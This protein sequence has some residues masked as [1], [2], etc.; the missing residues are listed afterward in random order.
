MNRMA[1]FV[2]GYTEVVFVDKLIREIAE[3]NSVLIQWRRIAGGTTCLRSNHQIQA[4]GPHAGQQ[5]F[6]VIHDCGGDEAVKTRM[7]EE[8]PLLSKAG[9]SKIVCIRD[10][11]PRVTY[12]KI[13][14]LEAGL[15]AF[16]RT[17]PIIVD[18][19]LSIMEVEAWFLAEHSH[20]ERVHSAIT[21]PAI[22]AALNFDP[23]T[24]DMQLRPTP[25]DDMVACYAIGAQVYAKAQAQLTVDALDYAY[26]YAGLV[27]KFPYLKRL[28][29]VITT[30]L[31]S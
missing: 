17:K 26:V 4:E 27:E 5:H 31:Q 24:D 1:I 29:D 28:C 30:F 12:A 9:Y 19:I 22:I 21:V 13:A 14:D 25:A 3:K 18:F 23:S 16:V 2:E 20:F 11:Y 6:I 8:Y 7:M 15:S 10:V